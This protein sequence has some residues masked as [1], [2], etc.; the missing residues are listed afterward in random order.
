MKIAVLLENEEYEHRVSITPNVIKQIKKIVNCNIF[1]E[2]NAGNKSC[3]NDEDYINEGAIIS[4]NKEN[5]I[6]NADIILKINKPSLEE[7]K[8]MKQNSLIISCIDP[9]YSYEYI[10]KASSFKVN[11]ISLDLIPRITRA[12]SMDVLSSQA[13]LAGYRAVIEAIYEYNKAIPMM[14]T[15]AGTISAAR[16]FIMGTGVA[17]LQAIATAKRLG[18]VVTATDIRLSAKEQIESLG[19]KFISIDNHNDYTENNNAYVTE[20]SN[21]DKKKQQSIINNHISKQDIIITSALI[22]GK[23]PPVLVSKKMIESMKPGSVVIDL[24]CKQ[25]GNVECSQNNSI[26]LI[27]NIKIIGFNNILNKISNSASV[28]YA[29]N[30]LAF[31]KMIFNKDKQCFYPDIN[32]EIIQSIMLINN[33][34]II[35]K[36]FIN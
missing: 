33:G 1:V 2:K 7:V 28:L 5:I 27:S 31:L 8:L 34:Q 26:Q 32:D 11:I 16:V 35:N 6:D 10:K 14:I 13:N 18:A 4:D 25:G 20:L 36:K 12:Q 24:A 29:N 30:I 19:A 21:E 17:G 9:Y 3:I 23:K 22:L 15:S